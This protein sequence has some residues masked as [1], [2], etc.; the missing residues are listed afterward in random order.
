MTNVS[1]PLP[2]RQLHLCAFVPGTAS[3][4]WRLPESTAD[5]DA[6]RRFEPF[7][8]IAQT[9]ERGKFDAMFMPDSVCVTA[10]DLDP[11]VIAAS[12]RSLRWD[13]LTL[14]PALAMVTERIGLVATANT[15]Y[16]EPYTVARRLSSLDWLSGGRAGWNL[17][18][19]LGGGNNFNLDEHVRHADR[20]ERAE[21]FIDVI[22]GLWDTWEDEAA[23]QDKARGIWCDT[24][25]MHMLDFKG[26]HF[27]VKGPLNAYRPLQ[28]HPV[29]VQAGSSDAG[30]ELGAR[31]AEMIFTAAQT[32]D[33]GRAFCDDMARRMQR[34]G[35]PR[36]GLKVMPGMMVHVAHTLEEARAKADRILE[37][38]DPVA[39]LKDLSDFIGIGVDLSEY[40]FDGP[41]PLPDRMPDTQ[42]HK[43]RQKLVLDLIVREKPTIRQL[44]RLLA[45]AGHQV[46]IG[47]PA[48]VADVMQRW[49]EAG[50]ADG[51]NLMFADLG[52]SI[53]D[54]VDLV[55]PELQ[56]R[57]LF[58]RDYQGRTLREHLGLARPANRFAT[59]R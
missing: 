28:G 31:T 45:A 46:L 36:E 17:V 42:R 40:P 21:E 2:G 55:V 7:K 39:T 34:Y 9:L 20:Y 22:R 35:R 8:A 14:L 51:F 50:A 52:P 56:R 6:A 29:I 30:R 57:G 25:K 58:R 12:P 23:V 43:S 33:E 49:V 44:L 16:N 10:G 19:S 32:I 47:T 59:A 5:H 15:T 13:P 1:S 3:D 27:A 18:T 38:T 37:F 24:S 53:T 11:E 54:F 26:K 4:A 41:V 48:Q